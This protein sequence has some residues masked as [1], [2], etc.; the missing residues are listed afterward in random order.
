G[1]RTKEKQPAPEERGSTSF[2][3]A[4]VAVALIT[5]CAFF[6]WRWMGK[7]KSPE[8]T[9]TV[10]KSEP[11]NHVVVPSAPAEQLKPSVAADL[12]P[13]PVEQSKAPVPAN[14]MPAAAKLQSEVPAD[15]SWLDVIP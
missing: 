7:G 10:V 12:T 15:A 4:F 13:A 3:R 1:P 5:I 14:A 6:A 11:P 2:A 9:V 8:S